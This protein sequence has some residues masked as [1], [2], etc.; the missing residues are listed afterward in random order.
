MRAPSSLALVTLLLAAGCTSSTSSGGSSASSA[1]AA[2]TQSPTTTPTSPTTT[3]ARPAPAATG[4]IDDQLAAAF[5]AAGVTPLPSPAPQAPEMVALGQALFFDKIISGNKNISCAGCHDMN[6]AT[7]DDLPTGMGDGA[8]GS[9]PNRTIG[10]GQLIAR[11]APPLFNVGL[12]GMDVLFWDSRVAQ[13][14]TTGA[15]LTT[16]FLLNGVN[17]ARPEITAQLTNAAAAQ[18][19]FPV[20]VAEEMLGQPGTNELTNGVTNEDI[21]ALIMARLVGTSNGT[22]GGIGGYRALF[23]SAFP[24]VASYDDFNFGH[25]AQAIAAFETASFTATQT[26]FDAYVGGD[27]NA[28]SDSQKRGGLLFFT[29]A[30][31][32]KCHNGPFLTDLQPHAIGVPQVG[33]GKN[34]PD[35]D[36]GRALI[37][38]LPSDNY[39]F[40]TPP[41]RNVVSTGPW[42]HDG[43]FVTLQAA[44][45][46]HLDPATS[47]ANYD[48]SQLPPLY[49]STFDT[50]PGR[51]AARL[52]AVDPLLGAPLSLGPDDVTDIL[53][54]LAALS[55]TGAIG[56]LPSA[57]PGSVP[58]GLTVPN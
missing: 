11:N 45:Q 57:V 15:F 39:K 34:Q 41:L 21:W 18:A 32:S 19:L 14:P 53:N 28:L 46:H 27:T 38:Q 37:T 49:Q 8:V 23:A 47:L 44:V 48:P 26:L 24:Q 56:S 58:S 43:A 51:N 54:F 55:D 6:A 2:T 25:A 4:S 13:D 10:T 12:P 5:T 36:L 29:T 52:A 3:A 17:P 33:P 50:D 16:D 20:T 1:P 22:V 40:R 42:M 35:E 9:F 7:G 31:C 30:N